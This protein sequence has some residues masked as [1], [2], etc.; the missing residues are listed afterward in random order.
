MRTV[1]DLGAC[2]WRLSRKPLR[3]SSCKFSEA[4]THSQFPGHLADYRW[5]RES[6]VLLIYA[7]G[8]VWVSMLRGISRPRDP[9]SAS[10]S[11]GAFQ[12]FKGSLGRI[13]FYVGMLGSGFKD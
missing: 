10:E 5:L 2:G 6:H 3:D 13:L 8:S 9:M 11:S 1:S 12:T 4:D 7:R